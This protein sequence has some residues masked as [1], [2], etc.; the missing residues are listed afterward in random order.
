MEHDLASQPG[1]VHRAPGSKVFQRPGDL[2]RA[3]GIHAVISHFLGVLLNHG[4]TGR[5][6]RRDL[7][8]DLGAIPFFRQGGHDVRDDFPRAFHQHLVPYL[9][10]LF[11]NEVKV[12]QRGLLHHHAA[13]GNWFKDGQRREH[14]GP[15]DVHLDIEQLGLDLHAGVLECQCAAGIFA[16]YSQTVG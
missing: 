9:D 4:A 15:A 2:C 10:V 1:D 11:A 16:R 12:M 13:D 3:A 8:A 14:A 7:K 6:A 5:A